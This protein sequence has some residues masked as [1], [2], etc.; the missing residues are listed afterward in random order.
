VRFEL[1]AE[2]QVRLLAFYRNRIGDSWRA[3]V[4]GYDLIVFDPHSSGTS[5]AECLWVGAS[6]WRLRAVT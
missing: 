3:A 4:A 1:F 6:I 5:N 2:R